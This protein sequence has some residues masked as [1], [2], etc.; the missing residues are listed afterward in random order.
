MSRPALFGGANGRLILMARI[1]GALT[2]GW[3]LAT[4]TGQ[5][6]TL[7]GGLADRWSAI[8]TR[9][10]P[11][12]RDEHMPFAAAVTVADDADATTRTMACLGRPSHDQ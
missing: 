9:L 2:H 1:V 12:Q 10:V 5:D 4:A 8:V 11:A 7:P 6:P 3:D